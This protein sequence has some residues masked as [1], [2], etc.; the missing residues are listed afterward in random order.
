MEKVFEKIERIGALQKKDNSQ[1]A[2]NLPHY[3]T[4]KFSPR[5]GG[6]SKLQGYMSGS[7][8]LLRKSVNL[9]ST[10][11]LQLHVSKTNDLVSHHSANSS[12]ELSL[13]KTDESYEGVTDRYLNLRKS[14]KEMYKS[15]DKPIKQSTFRIRKNH[16]SKKLRASKS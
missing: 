5:L 9:K 13:D 14:L 1:S 6:S 10:N 8:N 7:Q 12:R 11:D 4:Q 2:I 16:S 15:H 3:K